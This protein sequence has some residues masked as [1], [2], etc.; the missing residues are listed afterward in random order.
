MT[1]I[2][3]RCSLIIGL[4]LFLQYKVNKLCI[5]KQNFIFLFRVPQ[6]LVRFGALQYTERLYE[7]LNKNHM[8]KNGDREE[9]EI[10]GCSIHAVELIREEI[11][12]TQQQS[13]ILDSANLRLN[14]SMI[15]FF[16]WE[17]RRRFAKDLARIPYHKCR[18]IFY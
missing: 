2:P 4:T 8:F 16:L 7:L 1:L 14:S 10:R 12:K 3:L 18:C 17:Y 9:V 15:D 11:A 13:S 6:T 5:S